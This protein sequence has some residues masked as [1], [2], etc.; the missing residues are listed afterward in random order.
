MATSEPERFSMP[1]A[2]ASRIRACQ[3]ITPI[4]KTGCTLVIT[5]IFEAFIKA[6]CRRKPPR[7]SMSAANQEAVYNHSELVPAH[8]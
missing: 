2:S 1:S 5:T 4:W 6:C 7:A 8:R 3:T